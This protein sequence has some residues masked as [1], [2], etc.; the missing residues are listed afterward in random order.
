MQLGSVFPACYTGMH[1]QKER[2]C[3]FLL[4]IRTVKLITFFK[5]ELKLSVMFYI[6]VHS[7]FKKTEEQRRAF[8]EKK[9]KI[10]ILNKDYLPFFFK[11]KGI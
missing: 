11:V 5:D 7:S 3:C 9:V 2:R 10:Q 8:H 4:Y 6:Y 1:I